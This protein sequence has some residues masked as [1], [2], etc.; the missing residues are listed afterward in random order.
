MLEAVSHQDTILT[1]NNPIRRTA[2][3]PEHHLFPA[4]ALRHDL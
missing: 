1:G 3:E 2:A 4:N